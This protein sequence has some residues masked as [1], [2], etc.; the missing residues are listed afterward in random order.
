[1]PS[2]APPVASTPTEVASNLDEADALDAGELQLKGPISRP[3]LT[4]VA[5]EVPTPTALDTETVETAPAKSATADS[6]KPATAEP[7]KRAIV[8]GKKSSSPDEIETPLHG[9]PTKAPQT[10]IPRQSLVLVTALG[11]L[12]AIGYALSLSPLGIGQIAFL[13]TL[14]WAWLTVDARRVT[15]TGYFVLYLCGT[16]SWLL[17]LLMESWVVTPNFLVA[18]AQ[19]GYLGL[20][21][22]AFIWL[23]RVGRRQW[24]VPGYLWLP[25]AWCAIEYLRGNLFGGFSLGMLG[26]SVVDSRRMLQLADLL[27]STGLSALM[28]A[29]AASV[30]E[31]LWLVRRLRRLERSVPKLVDPRAD[32]GAEPTASE[33]ATILASSRSFSGRPMIKRKRDDAATSMQAAMRRTRD[34]TRDQHLTL[35]TL[36]VLV[37]SGILFFSNYYG[38]TRVTET[39]IWKLFEKSMFEFSVVGGPQSRQ[40]LIA[41]N[42]LL[43]NAL[44]VTALGGPPWEG[45]SAARSLGSPRRNM[46]TVYPADGQTWMAETRL[47]DRK[48]SPGV[49][50]AE[51]QDGSTT[52]PGDGLEAEATAAEAKPS[53]PPETQPTTTPSLLVDAPDQ[54]HQLDT[55]RFDGLLG[56]LWRSRAHAATFEPRTEKFPLRIV[57]TMIDNATIERSLMNVLRKQPRRGNT[58][59]ASL[60]VIRPGRWDGS[61][62]PRLLTRSVLAAAVANRC[63][64]IGVVPETTMAVANG[65]G[66]L[67][68]SAATVSQISPVSI[69]SDATD[70][71][72]ALGEAEAG[73]VHLTE[74]IDPRESYYIASAGWFPIVS[75]CAGVLAVVWSPVSHWYRTS[76]AS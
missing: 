46:L 4:P 66:K 21:L 33:Q 55:S 22:P 17:L 76:Q 56:R 40:M 24:S 11:L 19:V 53:N 27:G 23:G 2:S 47:A 41:E 15:V 29:C 67:F 16:L 38:S 51:S 45:N 57:C 72:D 32:A 74:M 75:F 9:T 18:F 73:V 7:A 6:A 44:V 65:D 61:A 42:Q 52:D 37:L 43:G 64:V 36:T 28:V 54:S 26:H 35:A 58:V 12:G 49:D 62:W 71:A 20:F 68:C 48:P 50:E 8:G 60:V 13:I 5:T 70:T 31:L 34:R 10:E 3:P 39:R 59:D 1:M 25:V 63:P 30:A 69:E 14:P